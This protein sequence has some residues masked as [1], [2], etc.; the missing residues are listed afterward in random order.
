MITDSTPYINQSVKGVGTVFA[1]HNGF[2]TE[3]GKE[4]W[5]DSKGREDLR[6]NLRNS[7]QF[8]WE[9]MYDWYFLDIKLLNQ[10]IVLWS[11]ENWSIFTQQK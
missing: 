3:K 7:Y 6:V 10:L 11:G 1:S 5:F 8:E 4:F 2:V 9:K